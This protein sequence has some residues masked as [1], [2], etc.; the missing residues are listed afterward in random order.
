MTKIWFGGDYNPDQWP[1]AART[2][3]RELFAQAN[4]DTVTLGIFSWTRWHPGPD[5]YDFSELDTMIEQVSRAGLKIILATPTA[6][7]PAWLAAQH[8]EVNR[9]DFEGRQHRFGGRHNHCP[10]SPV[11]RSEAAEI[12]GRLAERYADLPNLLVWHVGNEYGGACYCDRCAVGFREWLQAKYGTLDE[13]NRRWYTSFWS[14]TF[15][16]WDEI[17]PS[18]ALTE[19]AGGRD[20]RRTSFQAITLDYQRFSSAVQLQCYVIERDAI[21]AHSTDV[22]ITTNFMGGHKPL[23]YF[24]WATE[25]D[26]VSWDSYPQDE[27]SQARVAMWHDL[28][29][30]LRGGAPFWLME[31]TP[32]VTSWADANPIKRPGVMRLW[33]YQA[34]AHGSDAVLFFQLRQSRGAS[35]KM[36]GAVI[37]HAGRDD[38]RSFGE[39]SELGAELNRLDGEIVGARAHSEVA[40]IFDWDAWWALEMSDG[41]SRHVSYLDT[42]ISWYA[43]LH[44][45][46]ISVDLVHP[47]SDLSGYR[48]LLAPTLF[49]VRDG[50]AERV[51][52]AVS[53]GASFVT[54]TLSGRVDVDD[55]AFL[56]DTPGPFAELCGVRVDETDAL[57]PDQSNAVVTAD[58]TRYGCSLVYDLVQTT[59][60]EVIGRY[61][62]DFY[63]GTA[64]ITRRQVEQGQAWYVGS[65]L[66]AHGMDWL[67]GEV[68]DGA[69]V[70]PVIG[71]AV[72]PVEVT[73]RHREDAR[74]LFLL[75]HATAA[76][77][78]V[79]DRDGTSLLDGEPVTRGQSLELPGRGV[80]II[81]TTPEG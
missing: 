48:V 75:N 39:V 21:R 59:T 5:V 42:V 9:V 47:D 44:R 20:P 2:R 23:D 68:V 70:R 26:L 78:V 4:I 72:F 30:G 37:G 71:G 36:H 81:K 28:M 80:M 6:A 69:G 66:D 54:G 57:P 52:S 79:S 34:V 13:L 67:L 3:D 18:N 51:Q 14:H 32:N 8:P 11:F 74:Y 15:T 55:Q 31:Q 35:E 63:A 41:P 76:N 22:P 33:S 50:L 1:D 73:E 49:L 29:R 10:S 65:L 77:V 58:G 25:L 43:A 64:V 38:T 27:Q 40:I 62:E 53:A 45:R 12:A 61:A 16:A 19:Q 56:N 7:R 17:W 60:A 46:N 24:A